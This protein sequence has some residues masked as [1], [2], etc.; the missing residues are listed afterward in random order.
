MLIMK[1]SVSGT[2]FTIEKIWHRTGIDLGTT[3]AQMAHFSFPYYF[4]IPNSEFQNPK[5]AI[6]SMGKW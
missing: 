6:C 3:I 2:F 5:F 1:G 4:T